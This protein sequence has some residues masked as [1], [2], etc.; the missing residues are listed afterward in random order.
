[1]NALRQS[2]PGNYEYK[3]EAAQYYFNLA[4]SLADRHQLA[5]AKQASDSARELVDELAA[6]SQALEDQRAQNK[7][8]SNWIDNEIKKSAKPAATK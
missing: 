8:L 2:D 1:V 5:Q 3:S 7:I 6:P 4:C